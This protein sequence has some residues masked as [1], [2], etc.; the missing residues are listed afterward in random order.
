MPSGRS[1]QAGNDAANAAQA[2]DG[3]ALSFRIIGGSW[4][5]SKPPKPF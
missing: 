2:H 5:G 4:H 1:Q 3:Y